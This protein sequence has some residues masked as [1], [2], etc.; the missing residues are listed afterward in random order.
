[1]RHRIGGLLLVGFFSISFLL[2]SEPLAIHGKDDS[3]DD[4]LG[5]IIP[6]PF[7]PCR[8]ARLSVAFG[9][10]L[11]AITHENAEKL[12]K[13]LAEVSEDERIAIL[14][15]ANRFGNACVHLAMTHN[16]SRLIDAIFASL[17]DENQLFLMKLVDRYTRT[18]LEILA[19]S[20][21]ASC[22]TALLRHIQ[23]RKVLAVVKNTNRYGSAA[24]HIAVS[25]GKLDIVTAI[26]S[27]IP[28][29]DEADVLDQ[30]NG[31]GETVLSLA[32]RYRHR[33]LFLFLA[34]LFYRD[35]PYYFYNGLF[36]EKKNNK[37]DG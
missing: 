6:C 32:I 21:D 4:S 33:E 5:L 25:R 19:L 24:L 20:G 35:Y 9:H 30:K 11:M 3:K 1:V 18:A 37:K 15:G 23:K 31:Q 26:L 2:G 22:A 16:N 34:K 14:S 17:S 29:E 13:V 36:D 12:T 7:F 28:L 10:L 8:N 27:Q